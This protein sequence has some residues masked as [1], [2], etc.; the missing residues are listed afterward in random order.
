MAK[1]FLKGCKCKDLNDYA[2]AIL[3]GSKRCS[4]EIKQQ[5]QLIKQEF[6]DGT[7]E[8]DVELYEKY[9]KIGFLFFPEIFDWQRAE[10]ALVLCTFY[11]GT[12][13]PRWNKVYNII[14][15]GSGK[16]GLIAWWSI[17]LTSVYH[18]IENYDVDIIANNIDQ[19]LRPIKDIMQMVKKQSDKKPMNHFFKKIGDCVMSLKTNS[20]ITARSSDATQQ[21][22]LRTGAIMFNEIHAYENYSRLNVMISGLGK[23]ADPRQFYF[24][25]NGEVRGA[26]LDSVIDKAH[27]VL[28]KQVSDRRTLYFLYKLDD[29]EEVHDLD[30]WIKSNPSIE[31]MP[32]IKEE[33][34]D[35]YEDWKEAP[36]TYPAFLQKRFNLPEMPSDVE[37]VPWEILE[38]TEQPY[39]LEKL[40]GK[41]CV[42]GIDLSKTTDWTAVNFLFYDDD[43]EKFICLNHA[44]VCKQSKDL[45]GVK[46]PYIEWAN[47]GLLTLIDEK[48]VEP[49]SVVKYITD[50][51]EVNEYNIISIAID[52]FKK[53]IMKR[54]LE[55]YGF[56]LE[57]GNLE[58]VRPLKIAPLVPVIESYFMQE[59]FIWNNRMLMWSTNNAKV[60]PWKP[61]TTGNSDLG[62][63]LYGKINPRFRKTDPFMAFVHS[64][65]KADNLIDTQDY[66]NRIR[67]F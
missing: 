17:C 67:G 38:L 11:K 64:M 54:S 63:Q 36:N 56:S 18:G 48:E 26:V 5:Y 30:N 65:V 66:V 55:E 19:S 15:R 13:K 45:Q 3:K 49:E 25:T 23:I 31:Y 34:E 1:Y 2:K 21:D 8:T 59:R 27:R 7:I 29:K 12:K 6:E 39:D 9:I 28:N 20:A 44:F 53:G 4:K 37:V 58:I 47:Q 46:A 33:I 40:K 43:I 60:V 50:L 61:R 16:D 42:V 10:T 41:N 52:E 24:T 57:G 35:E 51:A 32:Q 62:N 22:G 14:G